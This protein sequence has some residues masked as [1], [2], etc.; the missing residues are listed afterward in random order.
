[1]RRFI[2][3]LALICLC[4]TITHAKTGNELKELAVA[5]NGFLEEVFF[6]YVEGV[7]DARFREVCVP[8]G[9]TRQQ[10][11]DVVRK[12]LMDNPATLNQPADDL[13]VRAVKLAWPCK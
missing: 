2:F 11:I 8:K 10:A 4:P 9:V 1:M 13:V 12:Y 7:L 6:G 3:I 5:T